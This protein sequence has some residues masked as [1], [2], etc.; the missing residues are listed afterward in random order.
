M[1]PAPAPE[2]LEPALDR[3]VPEGRDCR[4]AHRSGVVSIGACNHR[5]AVLAIE[6]VFCSGRSQHPCHQPQSTNLSRI[7][8]TPCKGG[9]L[10][11]VIPAMGSPDGCSALG[12]MEGTGPSR[13][14]E[15]GIMAGD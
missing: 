11:G 12:L 1:S 15:A 13:L 4:G 6:R 14:T 10:S 2:G 9:S 7:Y 5:A 3:V 8:P